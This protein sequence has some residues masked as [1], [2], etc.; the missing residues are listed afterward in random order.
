MKK[1][2]LIALL[3]NS[4]SASYAQSC[5][6]SGSGGCSSNLARPT[7]YAINVVQ[8]VCNILRV[9]SIPIYIAGIE[10]ACA[11]LGPNGEA[12]ITYN[13]LFLG[14]LYQIN[15]WAPISVLAHEVGHHINADITWY[16]SFQ[17]PWSRELRADYVSGYVL[18]KLGASLSDAQSAFRSSFSLF[19]SPSHP[20]TPR[21]LD[22]LTAGYQRAYQGF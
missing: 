5:A 18:F 14:N 16:G 20:D 9:P 19:G 6:F 1:L 12:I 15:Q 17:H 7:Q 10:N 22:A 13:P 21:R 4:M 11:S 8:S 2:L 3:F